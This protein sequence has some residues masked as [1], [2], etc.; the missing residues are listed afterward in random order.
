[1]ASG[2]RAPPL[3][4]APTRAARAARVRLAVASPAKEVR[5]YD[6][7][8]YVL[9]RAIT[10]DFALVRAAVGDRHGNLVFRR[11]CRN[12]NPL[13][14]MAGR[15]TV[16]EVERLVE[17]GVIDADQVHVPGVF[18]QRVVELTPAQA[19]DKRIEKRTVSV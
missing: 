5:A 13:A 9:E 17:P 10:T 3:S 12:F 18:V 14:A 2:R 7:R 19:A 11:S 15:V 6:G 4:R 1:M 8:D 16:A